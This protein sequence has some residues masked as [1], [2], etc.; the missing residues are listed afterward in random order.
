MHVALSLAALELFERTKN[1][2]LDA[3]INGRI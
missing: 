1:K 3:R 2:K